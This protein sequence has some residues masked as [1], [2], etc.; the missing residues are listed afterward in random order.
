MELLI[1]SACEAAGERRSNITNKRQCEHSHRRVTAKAFSTRS[2]NMR[3]VK[4]TVALV[5]QWSE[6]KLHGAEEWRPVFCEPLYPVRFPVGLTE[7]V[8]LGFQYLEGSCSA[9]A[10][11]KMKPNPLWSKTAFFC[12]SSVYG[13]WFLWLTSSSINWDQLLSL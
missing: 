8:V 9:V 5:R 2:Y 4:V 1:V 13:K 3:F 12:E 6:E 11:R 10:D 7:Q